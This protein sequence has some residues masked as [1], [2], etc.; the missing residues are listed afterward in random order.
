[1]KCFAFSLITYEALAYKS[2]LKCEAELTCKNVTS[3]EKAKM[4]IEAMFQGVA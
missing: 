1:M 2:R 3:L 4:E